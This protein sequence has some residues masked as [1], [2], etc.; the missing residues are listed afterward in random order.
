MVLGNKYDIY[1]FSKEM[2][3]EEEEKKKGNTWGLESI[4]FSFQIKK[5]LLWKNLVYKK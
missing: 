3:E 5:K 4:Y 2:K 1:L